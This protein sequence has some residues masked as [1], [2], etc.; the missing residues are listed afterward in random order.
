MSLSPDERT[1]RTD[2]L[3]TVLTSLRGVTAAALVDDDGFVLHVR[4]DFEIDT[5]AVGAAVQIAF[6]ASDRASQQ[7]EQGQATVV[8]IET[9]RGLMM[10]SPLS[11]G[12]VLALVADKTAMLGALRY[13]LKLTVPELNS[14]YT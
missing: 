1:D 6:G 13:E 4:R 10:L 8:L 7:V 3:L 11:N 2:A 9:T 14:L 12:F 5:D